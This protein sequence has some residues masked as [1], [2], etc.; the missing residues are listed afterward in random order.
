MNKSKQGNGIIAMSFI[1][2]IMLTALPLPDWAVNW[3]PAWVAIVL[4]YWCLAVPDRIGIFI[5]WF[6]GLLLDVQQGSILGQNALGM[7]LIALLTINSHQQMRAYPLLQQA[8]LVCFYLLFYKL[9]MFL[10]SFYIGVDTSD[11][12]YWMPAITSML[13][14]PWLFIILRD[15]RRKHRIS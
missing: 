11:W 12:T 1:V 4:I 3:R 7:I 8:V 9:I 14:W 2:A 5:A 13:L 10:I 15:V 6:L